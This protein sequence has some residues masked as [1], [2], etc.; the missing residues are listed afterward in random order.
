MEFLIFL[1][2]LRSLKKNEYYNDTDI[3]IRELFI[4]NIGKGNA[5]NEGIRRTKSDLI[6][7]MDADCILHKNALALSV[8]HFRNE[9][10]TAV[11]GRLLVRIDDSS[12]L[13][14]IQ[15]YEYMKTFHLTRRVFAYLNT[16]C[17]ISGALGIFRRS[18]LLEINGY[19]TDTVGEDMELVLRLQEKAYKQQK[20]KIVYEPG[21][22][23]YTTV[24]HSLKRLMR[25]CNMWQR[26]LMDCL[27]KHC[28]MMLNTQY[29]LLG[30]VTLFYQLLIEL[31]GPVFWVFYMV[32]SVSVNFDPL[33]YLISAGYV[34]T[35]IAMTLFAVS[36]DYRHKAREFLKLIPR[37]IFTSIEGIILHIAIMGARLYGMITFHWRRM[38][39]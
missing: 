23:C 5:L 19:D 13:G 38:V 28:H 4:R 2:E 17:L 35:Q 27:F 36:F 31:L 10:V 18:A 16:Q 3:L 15:F 21:A 22:I 12:L 24:P 34:L 8:R 33:N 7:V 11:G 32:I 37:L 20:R 9:D 14:T 29:G 6:C 30:V 25:Q 26:G 39:W 1:R